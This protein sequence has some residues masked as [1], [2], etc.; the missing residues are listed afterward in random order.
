MSVTPL[1]HSYLN[2]SWQLLVR[3]RQKILLSAAVGL[4]LGVVVNVCTRPV[5]RATAR[6]EIHRAP[7]RSPL[8]GEVIDG[9]NWQSDN[10]TLF[11]AA[12]LLT[13]KTMLERAAGRMIARGDLRA[14]HLDDNPIAAATSSLARRLHLSRLLSGAG[15]RPSLP[16]AAAR[17]TPARLA[18][19]LLGVISIQPIR[20]TRLVGI[21]AD[22]WDPVCAGRIV[23]TVVQ[24]FMESEALQRASADTIRVAYLRQQLAISKDRID[25]G[26]RGA[27]SSPNAGLT[28]LQGRQAQLTASIANFTDSYLK[29]KT[30]RLTV[31]ARLSG[32]RAL[33][34]SELA[35]AQELMI[36]G[37]NLVQLRQDLL[38]CQAELAHAR[39][40]YKEKHPKLIILL[41]QEM[42]IQDDIRRELRS[43]I[44][45]LEAEHAV[46][47][48]RE[49]GLKGAMD[50]AGGEL[51][52][53]QDRIA[54]F[55][56]RESELTRDREL[57]GLLLAK[58]QETEIASAVQNPLAVLVEPATVGDRPV[59]PRKALNV[60]LG[61]VVGCLTGSGFALM[62]ETLRRRIRTPHDVKEHL[63]VPV[64][65][66]I[67]KGPVETVTES[68]ASSRRLPLARHPRKQGM[69]TPELGIE[70][71]EA[72]ACEVRRLMADGARTFL[73]TSS[74]PAEGK[75]T[76]A[77][78]VSQALAR[79][80][81]TRVALVDSDRFRPTA[82]RH[83]GLENRRGLGE[84]LEELGH[85]DL[86][87]EAPD[88]FGVGDWIEL[89]HIQTRSGRL[90]IV[91]DEQLFSIF[92]SN[93]TI[94][95]IEEPR[96]SAK[97]HLGELLV[98]RG[99]LTS[100]Q[101][102]T[103]LK[104]QE[105][106]RRP[107][108][109]VLNG[110][111]LVEPAGI[112]AALQV[113]FADRMARLLMLRQPLC[114]FTEM[115]D[116]QLGARGGHSVEFFNGTGVDGFVRG[117]LANYLRQPF[118]LN[119]I[120]SY[121][122]DT[123]LGN[124]KVLTGGN[125]PS[126]LRSPVWLTPFQSVLSRL[127]QV[128]DVVIIDSPPVAVASPS[129]SIAPLADVVLLVVKADGYEIPVIQ[130]AKAR[131]EKVG[132][133]RMYAVLNQVNLRRGDPILHYYGAYH[134]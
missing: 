91:E 111:G 8:T 113:Q 88:N 20:D 74:G 19:W 66:M 85:F 42:S 37:G 18:D 70:Y 122:Q 64:L 5:F 53:V 101:R 107:L 34:P 24:T 43:G 9:N 63:E 89:L 86:R 16:T 41:S 87:K 65:G 117:Q 129:E 121:L 58:I 26:D 11:T 21:Q 123:S 10:V 77:A 48:S 115:A 78:K 69:G 67:A 30:D 104:V 6:L 130:T 100:T 50:Q 97:A 1:E 59:R 112:Q 17:E 133:R 82:H 114:N 103:A 25:Q 102:D 2:D 32:I 4:T 83:L 23:T 60:A 126:D 99:S 81:R 84:L 124:L 132:T 108:G 27:L 51:H 118:L 47:V 12:A 128:F 134:S 28:V 14:T 116:A 7:S 52:D 127:R 79:S 44:A 131:L 105:E 33:T 56:T 93:G 98:R 76:I 90:E 29:V 13:N 71:F 80:G 109:D 68:R 73:I 39:Q 125:V 31:E 94:A 119:Q 55:S 95:A 3:S 22:H 120:T 96:G 49:V 45:G 35:S 106:G 62:S 92:L 57:Y 46:L 75:S 61:L 36:Q 15:H 72:L 38:R 54:G 40:V 110:L